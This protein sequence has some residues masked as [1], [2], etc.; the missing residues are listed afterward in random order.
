MAP[1]PLS[2]PP[3]VALGGVVLLEEGPGYWASSRRLGGLAL[4]A[5]QKPPIPPPFTPDPN[6]NPNPNQAALLL[7]ASV[8]VYAL[9]VQEVQACGF[10]TKVLTLSQARA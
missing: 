4:A 6:P 9:S 2:G 5:S 7:A 8:G 10:A 3:F 1:L